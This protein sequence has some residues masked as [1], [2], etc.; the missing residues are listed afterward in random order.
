MIHQPSGGS[1]GQASDIQIQAEHIAK[2]KR[3]LAEMFSADTG[4]DVET[5]LKDADR[6]NYMSAEDAKEYG[7]IDAIISKQE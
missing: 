4:K 5:I 3:R 7:I 6:D 2:T 1:R